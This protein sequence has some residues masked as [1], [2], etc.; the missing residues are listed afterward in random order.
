MHAA[1]SPWETVISLIS[2]FEDG[3]ALMTLF[4]YKDHVLLA[5]GCSLATILDGM[6]VSERPVAMRI[7]ARLCELTGDAGW[8]Y[9]HFY[10]PTR[11]CDAN[12]EEIKRFVERCRKEGVSLYYE[13]GTPVTAR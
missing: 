13:D 10:G 1:S 7:A 6:L 4:E 12:A 2:G 3:L 9:A 11:G 5:N 8:T